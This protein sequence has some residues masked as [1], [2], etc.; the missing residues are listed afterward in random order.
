MAKRLFISI[1]LTSLFCVSAQARS[2]ETCFKEAAAKYNVPL[3]LLLA[4]SYTESRF[5]IGASGKNSNGTQ[6]YGL[7]QINSI[8]SE[9]AEKMGY[10]W[11]KILTSPC[12]NIMFGTHILKY[13]RK[14]MGSW[15]AAIGAYNAGFGNTPK[16]KKRRQRYYSLVM[17]HHAIA[18]RTIKKFKKKS[19]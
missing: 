1:F 16:A 14:R 15:A 6:D 18:Q 11:E 7:M 10:S 9:Q 19:T 17:R 3:D 4:V 5:K 2:L 8:W 12:D 13:N